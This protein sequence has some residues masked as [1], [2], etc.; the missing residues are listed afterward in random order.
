MNGKVS[1]LV[2]IGLFSGPIVANA[3][4][5]TLEFTATDFSALVGSDPAPQDPV[6]GSIVYEA[7]FM[8]AT[9]DS[10]VSMD[11]T[12]AGY[13]YSLSNTGF[14]SPYSFEPNWDIIYGSASDISIL[15]FGAVDDFW[16]L[17]DRATGSSIFSGFAYTTAPAGELWT[18]GSY[19]ISQSIASVPEPGTLGLLASGLLLVGFACRRRPV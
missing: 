1:A 16:L 17:W 7:A 18:A 5:I 3:L 10:I 2:A 11:L 9:I 15:P 8:G 12:I 19:T 6:S 14:Q 13:V 4:P